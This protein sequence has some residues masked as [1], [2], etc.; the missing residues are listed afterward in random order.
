MIRVETNDVDEAIG[1]VQRVYCPHELSLD[2]RARTIAT[3]L[4]AQDGQGPA[5]VSLEYGARVRID[6]GNLDGIT[7]VMHS[8]RGV[9]RVRQRRDHVEWSGGHTV[10]VSGNHATGFEFDPMFAQTSLRL[11]PVAVRAHCEQVVGA[12]LENEVR[13]TLK[14]FSPEM[15]NLWSQV[16]AL[17][18]QRGALPATSLEYL[19]KLVLDLLVQRCPHNYSHLVQRG[20]RAVP[21]LA[22]TATELIHSLPDHE[23]VTVAEV[24]ARLGVSTRSLERAFRDSYGTEPSRYLRDRRL[25]RVRR[26]LENPAPGT[27]VTDLAA[28]HGFYHLGRFAKYYRE[29]FGE[30]PSAT[31]GRSAG[32]VSDPG[33][34]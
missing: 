30:T 23:L 2:P 10:V 4:H 33:R 25:D 14:R 12:P 9:G 20:G 34:P 6:A 22:R 17:S 24:A 15:Q 7:L 1:A 8:T 32:G 27:S 29:R 28:A 21:R 13:F 16:L 26:Q 19:N 5:Q 11:D 18:Y 31:L 3:R